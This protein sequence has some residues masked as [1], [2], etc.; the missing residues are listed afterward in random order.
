MSTRDIDVERLRIQRDIVRP[1]PDGRRPPVHRR[2]EHFLKGPIPFP[3]LRGAA[4]LPGRALAVATEL[5][6]GAGIKKQ[7]TLSISLSNLR[8]APRISRSAASRALQALEHAGLVSV[9][10]RPG[11]KPL[12]T[13]LDAPAETKP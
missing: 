13:L 5:W 11:R 3:W 12:V 8:V 6:F 10:R 1:V 4:G 9:Q 2:G 7:R